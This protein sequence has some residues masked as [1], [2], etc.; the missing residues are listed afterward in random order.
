MLVAI[1]RA[2]SRVIPPRGSVM[3]TLG[4]NTY[5]LGSN[6][7]FRSSDLESTW[8]DRAGSYGRAPAEAPMDNMNQKALGDLILVIVGVLVVLAVAALV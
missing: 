6:R 7:F 8:G 1:R 2:S 4:T 3:R 5:V